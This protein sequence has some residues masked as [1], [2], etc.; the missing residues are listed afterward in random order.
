MIKLRSVKIFLTAL[1][2][3]FLMTVIPRLGISQEPF[4]NPMPKPIEKMERIKPQLEAKQNHFQ[5]TKEI[6]PETD[7]GSDYNQASA[8]AVADLDTGQVI[9]SKNLSDKLPMASLTKVMTAVVALD[10]ASPSEQFTVS[11]KAASQIPTKVMLQPGEQYLLDHLLNSVLISSA[12]DSAETV[13][14]GIDAK[15]G[16]GTFIKAM[17]AKAQFLDLKNTHFTNPQG[18]D[19][20]NHYSS[21]EDLIKLSAYALKE[22]PEIAQIVSKESADLTQG[23]TDNRFYLNNWNGLMGVYPGVSGVKIGN[24][25][26]AGHTTIVTSE[27]EGKK[28]IVVMLGAPGVLE[29]DLWTAELLDLGFNKVAGL[30]PINVTEN[31]L[32]AKY[33][34]WKYL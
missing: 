17:N 10:L 23:G 12:N 25:G 7:A 3:T 13:K 5:L 29:R 2:L 8:Y 24:T 31:Q 20:N 9:A 27:R 33:A 34:S 26:K 4:P 22:Y 6:V 1:F 15:Y 18:L 14:D 28:L 11:H 16:S 21:P 32:R 19:N 30:E